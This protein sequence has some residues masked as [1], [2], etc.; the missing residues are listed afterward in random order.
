M[1]II[2]DSPSYCVFEFLPASGQGAGFEILDKY[3][4]REAYL[5]GELARRFRDGVSALMSS[6]P[7]AEDIDVFLSRFEGLMQQPLRLH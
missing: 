4:R 5:E 7:T 2:Y 6:G 1:Q 3:T